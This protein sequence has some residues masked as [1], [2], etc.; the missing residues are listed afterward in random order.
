MKWDKYYILNMEDSLLMKKNITR[1][2]RWLDRLSCASE[3]KKWNSALIEADCL[4]AELRKTR[5]DILNE[6]RNEAI[7][8]KKTAMGRHRVF[9][10]V[11]A[12]VVAVLIVCSASLPSA[13]EADRPWPVVGTK[14]VYVKEDRLSWVTPEEEELLLTLR[15]EMSKS[16]L[17]TANIAAKTQRVAVASPKNISRADGKGTT[18]VSNAAT[19]NTAPAGVDNEDLLALIQIGEKALRGDT[20]AITIIN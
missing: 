9:V 3:K 11:R 1:M 19:G 12:S 17:V 14:T 16:D 18:N 5:E 15:S 4:H 10:A 6:A 7:A 8:V 13:V 20:R 2:Q